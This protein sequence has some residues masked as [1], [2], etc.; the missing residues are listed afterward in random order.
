[1]SF[2]SNIPRTFSKDSILTHA[3][4]ASG[5]YGVSNSRQWLYIGETDNIQ[6]RLLEHLAESGT[7][8]KAHGPTGFVFELCDRPRR[9]ERQ[10]RLVMEYEP[11]CNRQERR[12]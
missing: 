6:D 2:Q 5:L 9:P 3:P 1:L 4:A 10:D 7:A 12:H 8:L 11:V